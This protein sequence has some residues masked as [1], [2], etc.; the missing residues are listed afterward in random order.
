MFDKRW[1]SRKKCV[2]EVTSIYPQ[3]L[4]ITIANVYL[5]SFIAIAYAILCKTIACHKD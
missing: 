1:F 3:I 2:T 5:V 4:I